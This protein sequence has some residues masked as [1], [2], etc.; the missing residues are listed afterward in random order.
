MKSGNAQLINALWVRT[1]ERGGLRGIETVF[2]EQQR[3]DN[4]ASTST[5][6][7]FGSK[8]SVAAMLS[9]VPRQGAVPKWMAYGV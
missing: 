7:K 3:L 5:R 6:L 2:P 1:V 9:E 4:T 8:Y